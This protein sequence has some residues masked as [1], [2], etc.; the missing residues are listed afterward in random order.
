MRRFSALLIALLPAMA[1]AQ[2][3]YQQPV[4]PSVQ[5]ASPPS[6]GYSAPSAPPSPA[7][8]PPAP[9]VVTPPPPEMPKITSEAASKEM[10][11]DLAII[12]KNLGR[13]QRLQVPM[14]RTIQYRMLE[15]MPQR[16]VIDGAAKPLPQHALLAD[17]YVRK[18][19]ASAQRVFSGWMFA[20]N[21]SLSALSHP[22]YDVIVFGCLP[23]EKEETP[24]ESADAAKTP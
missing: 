24:K 13:H 1:A 6:F 11:V 5:P 2:F 10:R 14:G 20:G 3:T 23:I 15:V 16:C 22:Y 19:G 17:I 8:A 18:P 7:S 12:D 4:P 21:P 9:Q